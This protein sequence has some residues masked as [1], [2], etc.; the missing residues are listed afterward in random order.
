MGWNSEGRPE[1]INS[2]VVNMKLIIEGME[3]Y[4]ISE[5]IE[6]RRKEKGKEDKERQKGLQL[7]TEPHN[8]HVS[9]YI[10]SMSKQ[11]ICVNTLVFMIK[12]GH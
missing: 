9:A 12:L 3:V 11:N 7:A 4:E 2:K 8:K 10:K 6:R 5:C 1:G